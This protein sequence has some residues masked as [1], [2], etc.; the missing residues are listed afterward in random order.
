MFI[1]LWLLLFRIML[2]RSIHV[3]AM[4]SSVSGYLGCFCTLAVVNNATVGVEVQIPFPGSGFFPAAVYPEVKF[5]DHMIVLFLIF[6]GNS[7]LSSVADVPMHILTALHECALFSKSLTALVVSRVSDQRHFN[8]CEM[9]DHWGFD[10]YF[11]DNYDAEHLFRYLLAIC[12]FLQKKKMSV[13]F[14]YTFFS[15]DSFCFCYYGIIVYIFWLL[16]PYQ[17][18]ELQKISPIL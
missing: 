16:T 12:M 7:T 1:S 15:L 9:I 2:S 8:K 18:H 3:A 5:P 17:I 6:W 14:L 10:L 13:Q 4:H 11:P